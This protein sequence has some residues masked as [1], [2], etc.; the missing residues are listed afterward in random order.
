[1]TRP[2]KQA[3]DVARRLTAEG[4]LRPTLVRGTM[5]AYVTD[6]PDRF[7]R[8]APRFLGE[9]VGE[10]TLVPVDELTRESVELPVPLRRAG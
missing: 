10:P 1:M 7:R 3:Q 5:R 9:D 4:L 8:L 6:D 2:N